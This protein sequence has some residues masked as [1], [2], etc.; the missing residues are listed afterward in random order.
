MKSRPYSKI[1]CLDFDDVINHYKG[2][3]N[4]GFSVI[5]DNRPTKGVKKAIQKLRKNC[6]VIVHSTRCGHKGGRYAILKWLQKHNIVVDKVCINKPLADIY[7][8]DRAITF[9]GDWKQTLQ[10]I[11]K[12]KQ[13]SVGKKGVEHVTR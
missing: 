2:W 4:E 6:L 7:I 3:R 10:K 12:F 9:N 1:I 11:Q 5:L 8:D 13:W